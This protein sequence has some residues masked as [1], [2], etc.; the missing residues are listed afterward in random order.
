M[1]KRYVSMKNSQRQF[2]FCMIVFVVNGLF[3]QPV[4][5]LKEYIPPIRFH[6]SN[7]E[8][9]RDAYSKDANKTLSSTRNVTILRNEDDEN[10]A[11]EGKEYAPSSGVTSPINHVY[12]ETDTEGREIKVTRI[13][14]A[15]I[16]Y[17]SSVTVKNQNFRWGNK[18]LTDTATYYNKSFGENYVP[19]TR[20]IENYFY[21]D[22]FEADS[23][24][25]ESISQ[26]WSIHANGWTL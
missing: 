11:Y 17:D 6:Y 22:K 12:Y 4:H 5:S 8:L 15:D 10:I 16:V 1:V 25:R 26:R 24:Y 19:V 21:F 3:A 14:L 20:Y 13:G 18:D 23:F 7:N 2:I 9:L